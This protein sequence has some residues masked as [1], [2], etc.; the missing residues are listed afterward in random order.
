MKISKRDIRILHAA[1]TASLDGD[2]E[3]WNDLDE[4]ELDRATE[5]LDELASEIDPDEDEDDDD[6]LEEEEE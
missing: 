4:N 6:P 2:D 3:L 5:L 1:L